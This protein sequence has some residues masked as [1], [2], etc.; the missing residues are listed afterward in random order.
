MVSHCFGLIYLPARLVRHARK[1]ILK[2]Q[3]HLA[4]GGSVHH[5]LAAAVRPACTRLTS[6]NRPSFH[7]RRTTR[8]GRSRC[9]PGHPGNHRTGSPDSQTDI[10]PETGRQHNQ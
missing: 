10:T 2:N 4:M 8:R 7:E 9:A 6:T 3:R 1:R 5:L